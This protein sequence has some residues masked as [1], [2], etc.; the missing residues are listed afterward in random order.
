MLPKGLLSK[1]GGLLAVISLTVLPLAGCG[2]YTLSGVEV[3]TS[4]N[5]S[6]GIK[7]LLMISVLCAVGGLFSKSKAAF[8]V[9]GFA[10]LGSLLA[11]YLVL[12]KELYGNIE[13]KTGGYL[14][15]IGFILIL[16]DGFITDSRKMTNGND[17][18]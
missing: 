4:D 16:G 8:L 6:T 5:F 12:R 2:N 7:I 14:S 13:M 15:V 11:S 1:I 17:T 10:G 18:S 9:L 3:L